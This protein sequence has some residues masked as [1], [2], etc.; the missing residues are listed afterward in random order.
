MRARAATGHAD[1]I[2]TTGLQRLQDIRLDEARLDL[3]CDCKNK[4]FDHREAV[5]AIDGTSPGHRKLDKA[6]E[7]LRH[8]GTPYVSKT[9][10]QK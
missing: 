9:F 1:E 4:L 10:S 3:P 6:K 2:P 7:G 5:V 8:S